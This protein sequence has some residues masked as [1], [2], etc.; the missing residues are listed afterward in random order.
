[1]PICLECRL[2][3]QNAHDALN[4]D[5]CAWCDMVKAVDAAKK[6]FEHCQRVSLSARGAK[7]D[8]AEMAIRISFRDD[9][10]K[11]LDKCK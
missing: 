7:C 6:Y 1:M 4:R 11:A 2:C 5:G 10:I 9:A 8:A 3:A